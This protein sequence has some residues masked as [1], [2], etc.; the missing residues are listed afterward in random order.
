MAD[1]GHMWPVF[2]CA[3][4]VMQMIKPCLPNHCQMTPMATKQIHV[5]SYRSM[6]EYGRVWPSMAALKCALPA[7]Q[8]PRPNLLAMVL[9]AMVV[10]RY[11]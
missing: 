8:I 10:A 4:P 11:D 7:M 6:P 5:T 9:P 1:Y 2:Q 3:Q